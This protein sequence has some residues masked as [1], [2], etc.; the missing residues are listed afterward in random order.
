MEGGPLTDIVIANLMMEGQMAAVSR[1]VAQGLQHL[2]K[3]S[4]VHRDVKS[5]NVFLSLAGD[6]KLCKATHSYEMISP[7]L[8]FNLQIS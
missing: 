4:M 2:H 6:V 8:V 3:H 7:T 5:D 1:G